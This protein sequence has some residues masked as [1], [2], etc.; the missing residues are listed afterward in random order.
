[1]VN[2]SKAKEGLERTHKTH[3]VH[4]GEAEFEPLEP[5]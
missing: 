3:A 5:M 4:I 1:M 2:G